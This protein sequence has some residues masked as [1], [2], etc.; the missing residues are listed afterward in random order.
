[1]ELVPGAHFGLALR[2]DVFFPLFL[3]A[4]SVKDM[5]TRKAHGARGPVTQRLEANAALR[6]FVDV[7]ERGCH[8][9][10]IGPPLN[11]LLHQRIV[12]FLQFLHRMLDVEV[13]R[14][15]CKML[16]YHFIVF[17]LQSIPFDSQRYI[18]TLKN[19]VIFEE[20]LVH[21]VAGVGSH[22]PG[23][24]FASDN[25]CVKPTRLLHLFVWRYEELGAHVLLFAQC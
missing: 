12:F 23:V 17:G 15:Q 14:R 19:R 25:G 9:L 6:R 24:E 4:C 3:V 20:G 18:V 1:M 22:F 5:A 21:G 13:V 8:L 2:T 7:I 16:V 11:L 10:V